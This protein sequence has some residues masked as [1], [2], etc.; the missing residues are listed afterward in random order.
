MFY[1]NFINNSI[2]K[3]KMQKLEK[4]ANAKTILAVD[5]KHIMRKTYEKWLAHAGYNVI[6]A[7]D[8]YAALA[9]LTKNNPDLIIMDIV[10]PKKSGI[11]VAKEIRAS[12]DIPIL[13]ASSM[14]NKDKIIE[15]RK[16]GV[17][18]YLAKPFNYSTLIE[19][20]ELFLSSNQTANY[21]GQ[22][23]TQSS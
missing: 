5:D 2:I 8:G 16:V 20:V 18:A 11:Q 12:S 17:N 14:K 19:K 7:E 9:M 3:N 1:V 4:I 23:Y 6:T 22:S 10:M 21:Q 15:S 13:M